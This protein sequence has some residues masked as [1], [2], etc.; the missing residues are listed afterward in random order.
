MVEGVYDLNVSQCKKCVW[1][2]NWS[3]PPMQKS[4]GKCFLPSQNHHFQEKL[5]SFQENSKLPQL[6]GSLNSASSKNNGSHKI[7]YH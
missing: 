7:R 4:H 6:P 1:E 2:S 3:V 5:F